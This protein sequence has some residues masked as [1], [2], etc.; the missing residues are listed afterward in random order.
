MGNADYIQ[1]S[2]VS[3]RSTNYTN[4][5]NTGFP[6]ADLPVFHDPWVG[7]APVGTHCDQPLP[8][9]AG[10]LKRNDVNFSLNH[11]LH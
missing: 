2:F 4:Y 9:L 5:L 3:D 7:S 1:W 6:G 11:F 10:D 8:L